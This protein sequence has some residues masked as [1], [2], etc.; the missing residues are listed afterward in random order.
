M[1]SG[2]FLA[3]GLDDPNHIESAGE[4]RF[5]AQR[6]LVVFWARD[7]RP[8]TETLTDLPDMP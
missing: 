1:K 3:S 8:R 4:I 6:F 5:C 7:A 2:L